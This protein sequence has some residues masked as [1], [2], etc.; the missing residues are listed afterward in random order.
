M[1]VMQLPI[2]QVVKVISVWNALVSA[3]WPVNMS[4]FVPNALMSH[5]TTLWICSADIND[6]FVNVIEV[7]VL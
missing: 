3:V 7:W 5:S 2:D 4:L 1:W 6:V